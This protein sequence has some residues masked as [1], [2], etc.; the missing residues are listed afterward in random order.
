M[1]ITIIYVFHAVV[2][3]LLHTS[4][5]NCNFSFLSISY[6]GYK[7]CIY[8]AKLWFMSSYK[9]L[10]AKWNFCNR[11]RRKCYELWFVGFGEVGFSHTEALNI[12]VNLSTKQCAWTQLLSKALPMPRQ[13][14][15]YDTIGKVQSKMYLMVLELLKFKENFATPIVSLGIF[16]CCY[17]LITLQTQEKLI[18][19]SCH[20]KLFPI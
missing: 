15:K 5:R 3:I 16:V 6:W 2:P 19:G 11:D 14:M 17:F 8:I 10:K 20:H 7:V 9:D 13:A 18:Y 12:P 4:Q 1:A